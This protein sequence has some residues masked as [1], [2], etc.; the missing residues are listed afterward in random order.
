[1]KTLLTLIQLM[2]PPELPPNAG[3]LDQPAVCGPLSAIH[4]ELNNV[5]EEVPSLVWGEDETVR[6]GIVYFSEKNQTMTVVIAYPSTGVGCVFSSGKIKYN[7]MSD[8]KHDN[9]K[10]EKGQLL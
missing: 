2:N 6:K 9:A 5:Y 10:S 7:K 8:E 1:M 3:M 4:E